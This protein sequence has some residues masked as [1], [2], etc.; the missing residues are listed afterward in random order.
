[1]R[2]QLTAA[3]WIDVDD[4]AQAESSISQAAIAVIEDLVRGLRAAGAYD[5]R[6]LR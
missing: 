6:T 1:M 4:L 5:S 3:A 2:S